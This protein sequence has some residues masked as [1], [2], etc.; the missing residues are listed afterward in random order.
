MNINNSFQ[1]YDD[2]LQKKRQQYSG[3]LGLTIG[4][5][6][7]V[8]IETR[9]GFV[10]VR[11]RD[12]LSEVVQ[13]FND[14]VSP[15]YDFPVLIERKGNKWYVVGRDDERYSQWGTSAPFLPAHADQHSFD[16][17]GA[18]GGDAVFVYPDQF[19]P[20]LVYPSG[21]FGAGNLQVAP[22]LLKRTADY[23]YV[24]NTG[25]RN[26]LIYKPTTNQAI[27]GLVYL[28]TVSGNP[29]ILIASG[30]PFAG[31]ITGTAGISPY[32]P[33]P[34]TSDYEPLYAFRLVSG[35]TSLTWDNLYN[36]R[37]LVGGSGGGSIAT[38]S[39][40]QSFITGSIPF[41]ASNGNLT[42]DNTK[43]RFNTSNR[44]L[45]IGYDSTL[46]NSF[47][48]QLG[49]G[50]VGDQDITMGQAVLVYGTGSLGSPS[51]TYNGYRS[52][53]T[54][55][56]PLPLDYNDALQ[57]WIGA[58]FDGFSWINA[59]RVRSY[60]DGQ[61]ITG[62]YTPSRMDFEVTPSGTTSRRT[63]FQ[64][65]GNNVNIPTGSTYN[66][67]GVP[68][69]VTLNDNQTIAGVK[70]F[71][72]DPIIPE[73]AY[74]VGWNSSL[75]PPTKNAVYD[76][77]QSV[78][79]SV[80]ADTINN[81]LPA[82]PAD[83]DKLGFWQDATNLIKSI[84]WL[85]FKALFVTIS[86]NQTISDVKTFTSDPIIPDEAYDATTWNASLEPPTKNAVRDKIESLTA[87][88]TDG[89]TEV[90]ESW[91]YASAS[92]ITIPSDGTTKYRKYMKIRFKQGGGYKYYHAIAITSTLLTVIVNDDYTVANSAITDIAY[93]FQDIPFGFPSSFNYTPTPNNIT[94]G[95]STNK[96][97][98]YSI[99]GGAMTWRWGIQAGASFA[100]GTSPSIP[101]PTG[102]VVSAK[103]LI[104]NHILG[105]VRMAVAGTAYQGQV[106][107]TAGNT[108]LGLT[109]L[110]TSATYATNSTITS[111]V[112]ATWTTS[113][114]IEATAVLLLEE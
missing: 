108:A 8:N 26:L 44:Q 29:G 15:V 88:S 60:A 11:L 114:N 19:M 28:D 82:T 49:L 107:A 34:P 70:T 23:V 21:T 18:G 111:A 35:T 103:Y 98:S 105:L 2:G 67:G 84:T 3:L 63:Q 40:V 20:L 92:T 33:Y 7:V 102:V 61:W 79:S 45:E 36:A 6:R 83:A 68:G 43:L 93:S 95:S 54:L 30:T 32:I 89:W 14:K 90:S 86:G 74:A 56:T 91:S 64:I 78:I 73:E 25:T 75:E 5:S 16:R 80:V 24:G 58:G 10:Y 109:V 47:A 52:R 69:V 101:L 9:A 94:V 97:G 85:N 104:T 12:N 22:Y 100:M 51:P 62:A 96:T 87:G 13:V 110:N 37:Q 53:G 57:T 66:V 71:T 76:K 42:E 113:D 27:M 55:N 81:A 46:L 39:T 77:I 99:H 106:V 38:G 4:G 59:T 17:D 50:L 112:P 31:T 1:D 72:S 41:G 48:T 65:Y